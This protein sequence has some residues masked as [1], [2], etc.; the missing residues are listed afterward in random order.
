MPTIF[1]TGIDTDAGKS[2]A[3]GFLARW[4]H[5]AGRSVITQKIA[6]TGCEEL[7]EDMLLHRKLMGIGLTEA[8]REGLTCPYLFKIPASPHLSAQQEQQV[9]DPAKISSAARQLEQR[10]EYLLVEGVGGL[11]VPLN[12]SVTVLD[13][14]EKERYPVILVSSAKLGSINHTLLSLEAL[15]HRGLEA[16]GIIYNEYP[17]ENPLIAEDSRQIFK[18][19]L[20]RFGYPDALVSIPRIDLDAPLPDIDFSELLL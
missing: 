19:Y 2:F 1:I 16:L 20:T 15:Q 18:R 7:S 8:D 11:Y 5:T 13:Y 10:Y 14:L 3:T 6:Q 12:E 9:I 17:P 4:L